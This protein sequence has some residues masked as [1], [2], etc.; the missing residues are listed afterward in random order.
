[1]KI[2][3]IDGSPS[4]DYMSKLI[5]ETLITLLDKNEN[6]VKVYSARELNI[7]PCK[8]CFYCWTKTP[9]ICIFDDDNR[10]IAKEMMACDHMI[11][12]SPITF[13]GYSSCLKVVI[14]HFIQN[15]SPYFTKVQR[16]TH[17]KKRYKN[18]PNLTVI[19]WME[20]QNKLEEDIFI[21]LA[22]RNAINL[23]SPNVNCQVFHLDNSHQHISN[24]L[25]GIFNKNKARI[26][27]LPVF[28]DIKEPTRNKSVKNAILLVGS[29]RTRKSTSA[30]L[31][32]YLF[33][34]LEDSGIKIQTYYIYEKEV[35]SSLWEKILFELDRADLVIL[36]FPIYFDTLPSELIY[37]MEEWLKYRIQK[38]KLPEKYFSIVV[39]CGFPEKEHCDNAIAVC[40]LFSIEIGAIWTNALILTGGRG[41]GRQPLEDWGKETSI[42]R[43]NLDESA[44]HIISK[45][46][47]SLEP[48]KLIEKY[49]D[50][51]WLYRAKGNLFWRRKKISSKITNN[52]KLTKAK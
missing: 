30:V 19:G 13:G 20:K 8:G 46:L 33:K 5:L 31:G 48:F 21:N 16:K 6:E 40:R 24:Q 47:I 41:L 11:M 23:C 34:K 43:A 35:K 4:E 12:L 25:I 32:R 38:N 49:T 2:I 22:H 15:T 50:P 26:T 10:L 3:I 37:L 17:H 45:Q 52:H 18:Y 42:I 28:H 36:S 14:D 44:N 1:M 27:N 51:A 39:N 9:G 29:P 7:K